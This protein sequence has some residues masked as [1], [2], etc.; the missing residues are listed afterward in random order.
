MDDLVSFSYISLLFRCGFFF[1]CCFF[2]LGANLA[3]CD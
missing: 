2:L 3:K 1:L